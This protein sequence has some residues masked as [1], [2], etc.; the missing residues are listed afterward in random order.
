MK[1]NII[2]AHDKNYVMGI[3][4]TIPW[5]SPTDLKRFKSL[6][7]GRVVIMGRKT[8]DSLPVK[9]LPNR[10]NIVLSRNNSWYAHRTAGFVYDAYDLEDAFSVCNEGEEVF[11]IGGATLYEEA[12]PIADK[13]YL[14]VFNFS[15]DYTEDD[16]VIKFPIHALDKNVFHLEDVLEASD[17]QL[18]IYTRNEK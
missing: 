15:V 1:I 3:N 13:V 4:G 12:L 7:Q 17:H 14:S 18:H 11:I 16:E 6:T 8:W 5:H 9:P 2:A 10:K